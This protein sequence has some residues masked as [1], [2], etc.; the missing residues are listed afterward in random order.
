MRKVIAERLQQSKSFIPH[1]YVTQTVDVEPMMQLREQLKVGGLK[2][3][4]NDILVRAV[5]LT[6]R[7][8]PIINSGFNSATHSI[9]RFKT[10]DI[11]IAVSVP[12]GLITPIIRHA[13]YKN[14][15][16]IATETKILAQKAKM[17]KL[18]REEYVGGSFTI[19][20]LGMFGI[21]QFQG[22]INPPQ[23]AILSVGGIEERAIVR[24]GVVVP[25]KV[26]TLSISADHRVIDGVDAATFLKALQQLLENPALLLV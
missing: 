12:E 8:H 15:G 3:T 23:A 9:I 10:V 6:L 21:T 16:Q 22:I 13:D 20:N 14:L 17:G 5:A 24:Q 18:A 1:F 7:A 4:F 19:S 11:S 26:M 2:V 25:G